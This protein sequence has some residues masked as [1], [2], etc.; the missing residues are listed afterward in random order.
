MQ[1]VI[2]QTYINYDGFVVLLKRLKYL[3]IILRACDHLYLLWLLLV[4]VKVA[5]VQ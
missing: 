5:G 1:T 4:L 2:H 3:H